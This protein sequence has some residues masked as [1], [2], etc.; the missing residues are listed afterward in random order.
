MET[1]VIRSLLLSISV[2]VC[3]RFKVHGDTV[4]F[5]GIDL[6]RGAKNVIFLSKCT[7]LFRFF[8]SFTSLSMKKDI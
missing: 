7:P 6:L 4:V 8:P 3:V 5:I 1:V 2:S